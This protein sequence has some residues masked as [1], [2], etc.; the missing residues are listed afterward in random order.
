MNGAFSVP[1][2]RVGGMAEE[3]P[4]YRCKEM[5]P[6][7]IQGLTPKAQL[8]KPVPKGLYPENQDGISAQGKV[9][10]EAGGSD[11]IFLRAQALQMGQLTYRPR[12]GGLAQV[13]PLL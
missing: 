5:Q 9:E 10:R 8:L 12:P 6:S 4:S 2:S 1:L 13:L 3:E 7:F 11:H